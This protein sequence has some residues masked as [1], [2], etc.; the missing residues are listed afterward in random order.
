M[1]EFNQKI[2]IS[3]TIEDL[4]IFVDNKKMIRIYKE[5]TTN[6]HLLEFFKTIG[7]EDVEYEYTY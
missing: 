3:E 2:I 6:E 7:F 4:C 5:D 1:T